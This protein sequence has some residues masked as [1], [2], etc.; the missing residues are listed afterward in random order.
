MAEVAARAGVSVMTVSYAYSQPERVSAEARDKVRR[1]A[2][3]LGYPGPDPAARSLRR[4][5]TGNLGVAM[6]EHLTYAFDDPQA[7]RFLAGVAA[8]CVEHQMGLTLIPV[9]GEPVDDVQRIAE[10]AV[11]GFI[12]WTSLDDDP[13]MEAAVASGRPVVIQGGVPR[14][15]LPPGATALAID[16][17]AAAERIGRVI[18]AGA[19]RPA[20][21]SFPHA[22]AW[23]AAIVWGPDP[24]A[25]PLAVTRERLRGFQ[26]AASRAGIAWSDVAVAA[27]ARNDRA[28][29]R[30]LLDGL[31]AGALPAAPLAGALPAAAGA[32]PDAVAAMSDEL[33]LATLDVLAAR[34]LAVPTDVAVSGWDDTPA[35]STAGLTTVRQSL[36][37]QGI[38]CA[39]AVLG[40][41]TG[42]S[43]P[44]AWELVVRTS[45][46]GV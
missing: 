7:S 26:A 12:L 40:D 29:A 33:A 4:G 8:V 17:R 36:Q 23:E 1:S 2:G 42:S 37:D 19:R 28:G 31:F 32:R 38:R 41:T 43:E 5:R 25:I 35:A 46:R 9:S 13:V 14:S 6:G 27:V 22:P 15:A 20:I 45:T 24:A 16:N 44:P 18:F 10:A 39:R 21:V 11:D 3:A 30:P 34:G